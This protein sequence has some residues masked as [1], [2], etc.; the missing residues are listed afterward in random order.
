MQVISHQPRSSVWKTKVC[1][2]F[3]MNDHIVVYAVKI[4][5]YKL[6]KRQQLLLL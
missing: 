3:E 6:P 2:L 5:Q 4:Q 1:V